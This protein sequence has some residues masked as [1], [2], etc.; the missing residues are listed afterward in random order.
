MKKN[1]IHHQTWKILA[2]ALIALAAWQSAAVQPAAAGELDKLGTSLKLIPADAAFYSCMLRNREQVEAFLHSNAWEKIKSMPSL[3]MGLAFYN[4][5]AQQQGTPVWIFQDKMNNPEAKKLINLAADMGSNEVFAYGDKNC[6]QFAELMQYIFSG[7]RYGPAI[8]Q[9]TGKG[10]WMNPNKLNAKIVLEALIAHQDLVKFPDV[11]IG[12][13]LKK[14]SAANEA[15]IKLEAI[16]NVSLEAMPMLKG[17]LN[18][19][20]IGDDE[21]LVLRLNGM[22]IPWDKIQKEDLAELVNNPADLDKLIEHVKKMEFVLAMG[23]RDKDLLISM[24]SSLDCI[25]NLGSNERLI[26]RPELK[27]LEK[28]ANK[29]L[30]GIGYISKQ[31]FEQ[32]NNNEKNI[33][34][35]R[36]FVDK[37]VPLAHFPQ[38]QNQQIT[39]DV[40]SAAADLKNS[41]PNLGAI[42]SFEFLTDN[43]Y[44]GYQY[45]WGK[46]PHLDGSKPLELLKHMDGNPILGLVFRRKVSLQHYDMLAKWGKVGWN[47]MEE[48][49][50]PRVPEEER[51]K[52]QAFLTELKP[53]LNRLNTAIH[54]M[55]IPAL[56]DGQIGLVADAKQ[57]SKQIQQS[58]PASQNELPLI[59]PALVMGMSN[60]DLLKQAIREFHGVYNDLIDLIVKQPDVPEHAKNHIQKF[61]WPEA[62]VENIAGGSSYQYPLPDKWGLDKNIVPN[63][64]ISNKLWIISLST[65]QTDRLLKETPL[66]VGGVLA[67]T[68]RPLAVA[69]CFNFN[70]LIAA[71]T[72][73]VNYVFERIPDQQMDGQKELILPQV[74]T[75]LEVL[76]TVKCITSE[77]YIEDNI[78]VSHSLV[79]IHD[80]GK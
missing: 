36:N 54:D 25:K 62:K 30:T 33:D 77:T 59:E 5:Q 57:T 75:L 72:P 24:G 64:A 38:E 3:Q 63:A 23:V 22:M 19:E 2:A 66:R 76:S 51:S 13:R 1:C 14:P 15:L 78:M 16:L 41:L 79:E 35:L 69:V 21:F 9:A 45:N 46:N 17:H 42:L 50:L 18:R 20:T 55:W 53:L 11:L 68:D 74:H 40:D 80:L 61:K 12:F 43:G 73:W 26:D 67:S 28:F 48:L 29:K 44:E 7:M 39:K 10:K 32:L 37:M 52:V 47:Y 4:A 65:A 58:M 6:T 71:L 31:F 49:A 27:P 34:D 8:H 60:A 56:A 70:E